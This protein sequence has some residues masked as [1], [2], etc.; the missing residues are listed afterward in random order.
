MKKIRNLG[1]STAF[2]CET[3]IC[4]FISTQCIL[5]STWEYLW[6]AYWL[7]LFP[8]YLSDRVQRFPVICDI[9]FTYWDEHAARWVPNMFTVARCKTLI[10][11]NLLCLIGKKYLISIANSRLREKMTLSAETKGNKET[12]NMQWTPENCTIYFRN[13]PIW[14]EMCMKCVCIL[15]RW[16]VYEMCVY[17]FKVRCVWNVCVFILK[18]KGGTEVESSGALHSV[19]V[20]EC[21]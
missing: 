18:R 10:W 14:G 8:S 21:L 1:A 11:N 19:F 9:N 16:D 13:W 20:F 12:K 2:S 6:G 5:C 17:S 3:C 7:G 15:L 4:L